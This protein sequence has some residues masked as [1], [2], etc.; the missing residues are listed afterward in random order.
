MNKLK[1]ITLSFTLMSVLVV[2]AFAGETQGPSAPCVPGETETPPC[3]SQ[4]LNDGS[5]DP[6][7][8]PCPPASDAIDVIGIAE[9][10]LSVL[11]LF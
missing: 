1:Q 3:S 11:S 4:S 8:T 5:T 6:G 2:A 9:I 10:A 7:E